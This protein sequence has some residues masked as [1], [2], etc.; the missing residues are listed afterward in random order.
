[1]INQKNEILQAVNTLPDNATWDDALYTLYL[2]AKIK[3]SEDD[4][5]NGRV[6]TLEELDREMDAKYESYSINRSQTRHR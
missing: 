6:I 1:M 2:Q 4:I 3:R 5:K